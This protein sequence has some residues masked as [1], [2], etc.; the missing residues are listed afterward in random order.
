LLEGENIIG[1]EGIRGLGDGDRSRRW[2]VNGGQFQALVAVQA[3]REGDGG[4]SSL[5]KA[6]LVCLA[7][8]RAVG[9]GKG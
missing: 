2:A 5:D 8:L 6:D 9:D 4:T 7:T 3:Q 1:N